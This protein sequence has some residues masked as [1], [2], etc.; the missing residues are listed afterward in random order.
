MKHLIQKNDVLTL[1]KWLRCQRSMAVQNKDQYEWLKKFPYVQY[2][3]LQSFRNW[4]S[5]MDLKQF[6]H[7]SGLQ[8]ESSNSAV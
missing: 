4:L 7:G 5:S 1:I 6:P 8:S 2:N 3:W